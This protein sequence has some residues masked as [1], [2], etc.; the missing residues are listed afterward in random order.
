[1]KG[2][3]TGEEEEKQRRKHLVKKFSKREREREKPL[4]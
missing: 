1:M 4:L 2:V 3:R